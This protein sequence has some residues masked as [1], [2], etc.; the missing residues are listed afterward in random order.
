MF[1]SPLFFDKLAGTSDLRKQ[2]S[3]GWTEEQIRATWSEGLNHYLGVR[4]KYLLYP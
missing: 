3:E 1:T 4:N 2:L